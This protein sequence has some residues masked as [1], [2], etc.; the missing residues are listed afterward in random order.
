MTCPP[1]LTQRNHK[2]WRSAPDAILP[3]HRKTPGSSDVRRVHRALQGQA[4]PGSSPVSAGAADFVRRVD[5]L[6]AVFPSPRRL[7]AQYR[8][9]EARSTVTSV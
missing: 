8:S 6:R 4:D 3:G 7:R 1:P 2:G 9:D 5:C